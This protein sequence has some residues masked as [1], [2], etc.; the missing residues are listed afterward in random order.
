MRRAAKIDENQKEIV[1]ALRAMGCSVAITS[2]VGAGFT[3]L[4][5]G[6]RGVNYLVEIKDGSKPPSAQKLTPDQIEFHE[7]WRG[8]KAVVNSVDAAIKLLNGG[9]E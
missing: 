5:V 1:Q 8:Q 2:A 9:G 3:D 6:Y 7:S 4:V